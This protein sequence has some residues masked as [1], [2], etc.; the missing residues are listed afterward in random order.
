MT[1]PP[2]DP[3]LFT[4]FNEIGIISQLSSNAFE[5]VM[6]R[7]LTMSQFSVLNNLARLG[8]GKSP[9]HLAT[10]FQ[11]TRGAMTNTLSKLEASGFVDVRAD[12]SDGRGKQVFLTKAGAKA[13]AAALGGLTPLL[14][15]LLEAVPEKD[16]AAAIP[17]LARIRAHLDAARD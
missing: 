16:F 13:R 9:S 15:E 6:P 3:A 14:A 2:S 5:R 7:G 11:V 17:F 8:D 10:A 12:E 4:F 1:K